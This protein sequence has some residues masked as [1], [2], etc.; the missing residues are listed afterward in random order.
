[1]KIPSLEKYKAI[2]EDTKACDTQWQ[3]FALKVCKDF[4]I[5]NISVKVIGKNGEEKIKQF[6]YR[7]M[8]FRHAKKNLSYLQGRVENVREKFGDVSD[9]GRYLIAT[10]RSKKPWE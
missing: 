6:K 5:R 10:F 7:D 9:K 1:M 4:N 3:D 8:I 2:K